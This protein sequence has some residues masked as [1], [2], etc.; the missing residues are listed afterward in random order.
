MVVYTVLEDIKAVEALQK[1][2]LLDTIIAKHAYEVKDVYKKSRM[3]GLIDWLIELNLKMNAHF[4][5]VADSTFYLA[6][7]YA[8]LDRK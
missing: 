4:F 8:M 6:K 7:W 5:Y 2:I 1:M 3:N